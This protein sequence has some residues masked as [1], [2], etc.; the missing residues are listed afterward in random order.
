LKSQE[1]PTIETLAVGMRFI[2]PNW[3]KAARQSLFPRF[4]TDHCVPGRAGHFAKNSLAAFGHGFTNC[5]ADLEDALRN[6]ANEGE[7]RLGIIATPNNKHKEAAVALMRAGVHVAIDKPLA[8]TVDDAFAIA[9]VAQATG[10]KNAVLPTYCAFPANLEARH[11]IH[12]GGKARKIRGGRFTYDQGWLKKPLS[13]MTPE[14]GGEQAGWR[15]DSSQSGDGGALGDILSHLLF[16]IH[17]ITGL[18]IVAVKHGNLRHVVEGETMTLPSGQQVQTTDDEASVICILE[19]G[20]EIHCHAVQYASGHRN[21]NR[22]ELWIDEETFGWDM[23]FHP[24][25]LK[26]DNLHLASEAFTCPVLKAVNVMPSFH[27]VGWRDAGSTILQW[28]GW[29]ITG[30]RPEGVEPF[31]LDVLFGLNVNL[32]I[33]AVVKSDELEG[34]KVEV[35]WINSWKE[36]ARFG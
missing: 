18:S 30:T 26:I 12:H 13:E 15:K 17:F 6:F 28:L 24:E 11:R 36:L 20:A 14:T 23:A 10:M 31:P 22:W 1:I 32:V 25:I 5:Y 9:Q 16:Q 33:E 19:N 34:Q 2:G 3:T 7:H 21:D 27:G 4:N 35:D 8:H 29:E